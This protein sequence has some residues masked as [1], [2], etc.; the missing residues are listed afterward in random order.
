MRH[1]VYLSTTKSHN[2]KMRNRTVFGFSMAKWTKIGL[3]AHFFYELHKLLKENKLMYILLFFDTFIRC[4]ILR[5]KQTWNHQA[6]SPWSCVFF[7][8]ALKMAF[9]K[10]EDNVWALIMK[11]IWQLCATWTDSSVHNEQ[12]NKVIY[13]FFYLLKIKIWRLSW[14]KN[15]PVGIQRIF[16]KGTQKKDGD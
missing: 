5:W 2:Y 7:M 4:D 6:W 9:L 14:A 10:T 11:R 15:P 3:L 13:F 8:T 1:R 12:E 16:K